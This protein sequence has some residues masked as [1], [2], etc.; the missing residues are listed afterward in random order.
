MLRWDREITGVYC[1]IT[2]FVLTLLR[3][4]T[5]LFIAYAEHYYWLV[6]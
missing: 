2:D 6:M 3:K 4:I 1:K 5:D